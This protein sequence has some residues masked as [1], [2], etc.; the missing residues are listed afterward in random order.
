MGKTAYVYCSSSFSHS[1]MRHSCWMEP[2]E[3]WWHCNESYQCCWFF[4]AMWSLFIVCELCHN[5]VIYFAHPLVIYRTSMRVCIRM[6]R[7]RLI[8]VET[9]KELKFWNVDNLNHSNMTIS[10][11]EKLGSALNN[12]AFLLT[13]LTKECGGKCLL[14][15]VASYTPGNPQ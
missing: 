15:L 6:I 11:S 2:A 5:D 3:F 8:I 9:C 4:L 14:C 7:F 1:W 10:T 13:R 12:Q